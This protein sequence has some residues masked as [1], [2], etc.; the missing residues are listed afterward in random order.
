MPAVAPRPEP[1]LLKIGE[2][3]R[4][5]GVSVRTIRFWEEQGLVDPEATTGGGFRLYSESDV[6]RIE[7]ILRLRDSLNFTLDE[8]KAVIEAHDHVEALREEGMAS[9]DPGRKLEILDDYLGTIDR[10]RRLVEAKR[11]QLDAFLADLEE[12]TARA[13]ARRSEYEARLR[14]SHLDVARDD[15]APVESAPVGRDHRR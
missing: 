14:Q 4:R 2:V 13:E 8:V 5:V 3:A 12:R 1:G 10:Q 15:E 11:D 9:D 7:T 6:E